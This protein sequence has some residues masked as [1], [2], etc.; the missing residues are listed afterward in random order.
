MGTTFGCLKSTFKVY[1]CRMFSVLDMMLLYYLSSMYQY[2]PICSFNLL[3]LI[4]SVI[5]NSMYACYRS[6]S[7][8]Y[9][10]AIRKENSIPCQGGRF[11]PWGSFLSPKPQL[12]FCIG[13][14]TGFHMSHITLVKI[15]YLDN[16]R[17]PRTILTYFIHNP[18]PQS[19]SQ[20]EK[21]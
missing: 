12:L 21:L 20:K 11:S 14:T 1:F 16:D 15:I 2:L 9:T 10:Q 19:Q 5:Q 7:R 17:I 8:P 18:P 13:N 3:C 4:N 6:F